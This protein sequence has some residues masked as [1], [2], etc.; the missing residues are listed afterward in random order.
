[1]VGQPPF[2]I[3]YHAAAT[4]QRPVMIV[5][6]DEEVLSYHELLARSRRTARLLRELGVGPGR[7]VA[8]VLG[9][10]PAFA[11]VSWAARQIGADFTPISTHLTP[12]E[13]A[14]VIDDC[15]APVVIV[16]AAPADFAASLRDN[17]RRSPEILIVADEPVGS[18]S[19]QARRD[20]CAPDLEQATAR[21]TDVLYSG[22][23]TGRPKAIVRARDP[24]PPDGPTR[25]ERVM[26]EKFMLSADSVLL[27]TVPLYH[28]LG[29]RLCLAV[30]ALG[31]TCVVMKRFDPELALRAIAT[32]GCTHS[33]WVPTML[34]RLLKLPAQVRERYD[35]S[36][37][38]LALH[39]AAP[40]PVEAK[41]RII[42]WWGP[43]VV[44]L[45]ASTE[46][47][48]YHVI[49]SA[50]WLSHRG[51]VGRC[52]TA[53]VHIL[54]DA[55]NE[56]PPGE[57]GVV[58]YEGGPQFEYRNA[59][60]K[61]AEFIGP[62][63][64][65]SVGD[66]GYLD[67]DDYLYVTGRRGFRINTGGVKVE[68]R[69]VEDRLVLHAKVRDVAVIGLP[70]PDYGQ[71]VTAIV[72]PAATATAGDELIA[73]L[74]EWCR[75]GLSKIKCPKTIIFDPRLPRDPNG[76]VPRRELLKRYSPES[77]R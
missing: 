46:D 21:G 11:E 64:W 70:D 9:N 49:S 28:A 57:Q 45:L 24:A 27:C 43:I 10:G 33:V 52:Y 16:A 75:A 7:T 72:E 17:L 12:A 4:P 8:M 5:A 3:R 6:D 53:K 41:A 35:L 74:M 26:I 48:G 15:E 62:N 31:G 30:Q 51:S 71:A 76:K 29:L 47:A 65:R 14:A 54:D 68:P 69:E 34:V 37:L 60:D 55:G 59:P 77:A 22:G 44:E 42:D 63:G 18:G 66:V 36:S 2:H 19:Y 61:T 67:D 23:T 58:H 56:V 32:H 73:E 20:R 1:M 39:A 50:E 13:A 25:T 38:R 40:C